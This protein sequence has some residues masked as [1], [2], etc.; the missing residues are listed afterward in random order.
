MAKKTYIILI[1]AL[2]ASAG[3]YA[4]AQEDMEFVNDTAFTDTMRPPVSFKHDDH[5]EV[6]A[7]DDCTVCHHLYDEAGN[8]LEDESSEDMECGE[9][10][11]ADS[12]GYPIELV[13]AF[14]LNCRGC[15]EEQKAGPVV[16]GECHHPGR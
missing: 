2:L 14:H 9:C 13:R 8:L 15:H 4:Y 1:A 7:I 3:L 6:A 16:C 5:N 10:H 11:G 12:R